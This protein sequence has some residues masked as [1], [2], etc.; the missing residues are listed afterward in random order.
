M[1]FLTPAK[2]ER[3][4]RHSFSTTVPIQLRTVA[5]ASVIYSRRLCSAPSWPP[6]PVIP[7]VVCI[8]KGFPLST[9]EI[10]GDT[11]RQATR[12]I[13]PNVRESFARQCKIGIQPVTSI[14]K[15]VRR[16]LPLRNIYL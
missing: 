15:D 10:K 9:G 3:A 13:G 8:M 14:V 5:N 2:A 11:A 6:H 12:L 16:C 7:V 1:Q 4:R